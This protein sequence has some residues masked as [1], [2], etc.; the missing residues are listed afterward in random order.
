MEYTKLVICLSYNC[1][2]RG[3]G[4]GEPPGG[5]VEVV[6]AEY[7]ENWGLFIL[8]GFA[9]VLTLLHL[10]PMFELIG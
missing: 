4:N 8:W 6:M 1:E 9:T 2:A 5:P 3:G 10:K 7:S